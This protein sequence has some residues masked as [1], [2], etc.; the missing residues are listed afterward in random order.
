MTGNDEFYKAAEEKKKRRKA[1]IN[2]VISVLSIMPMG[3]LFEGIE[4]YE[5]TYLI[6]GLKLARL[7]KN[8]PVFWIFF[9][10]KKLAMNSFRIIEVLFTYYFATHIITCLFIVM[11]Y[12]DDF[13]NTWVRRIPYP[14][15][16]VYIYI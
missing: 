2:I 14:Y 6:C 15:P 9:L 16:E 8:K 13:N 5:P 12:W 11:M 7:L 4:V 10:L 1:T 3:L